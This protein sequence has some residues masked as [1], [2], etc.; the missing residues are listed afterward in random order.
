EGHRT[1]KGH[2]FRIMFISR[3]LRN[4]A[5]I[6]MLD[7]N[8]YQGRGEREPIVIP[9][10]YPLIIDQKLFER[11]QEKLKN[12]S[13]HFQNPFAH[14]TEYLLSRL[15]VC[16][17]CGHHYLGTSAKS[18][19]HRYYSC[20]TYL[21]R[22]K[23]ACSAPLLN[24]EK[25]EEAVLAQIQ[26]QILSEENV[27]KYI[28]LVLEQAQ[29]SKIE[30]SADETA[31][32]MGLRDVDAKLKRWEETLE[33]GLLSLE[34]CAARIREL[35]QQR[36]ALLK[37][38]VELHK[39]ARAGARIVPIPTRLMEEYGRQIQMRLRAKKIGYKKEFLREILKEVRVKG[40]AVR[41]IY[42][43]PMTVRTPPSEGANPRTGEFFTLYQM[44]EPMGVEPTASRVRFQ[45]RA[46]QLP[47]TTRK[48][49]QIKTHVAECR[50]LF[51]DFRRST[52]LVHGQNT[53]NFCVKSC[54][55]LLI[56]YLM[57]CSNSKPNK[58]FLTA[59]RELSVSSKRG[60]GNGETVKMPMV[61]P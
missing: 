47:D 41:L 10:F 15:V 34:D 22:G 1:K 31:V 13:D 9:G 17:F 21:R 42:K 54:D 29:Q 32:E 4:R 56:T 39:K 43:L 14:K 44:V 19:K 2:R 35:R 16:D 24:K 52:A 57:V 20:A 40:N 23:D 18:G 25:L 49:S 7:Y 3:T 38:K 30:P 51:V 6:G 12:E 26:E 8:R 28:S 48:L 55:A 5:Y 33:N 46:R 37:R 53:D 61:R 50:C 45:T 60:D 58:D 36:E 59:V 11:V 27:R